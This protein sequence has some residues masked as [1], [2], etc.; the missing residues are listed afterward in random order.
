MDKPV[1]LLM[2]VGQEYTV[3]EYIAES[4]A[5]GVSKR[6]P[7]T[8][9]PNGI[10]PGVSRL[11]LWHTK[12][13][14]LVRAEACT[15]FD[16][17]SRLIDLGALTRDQATVYE[18]GEM[19]R[20]DDGLLLPDSYVPPHILMVTCAIQKLPPA[21]RRQLEKDFKIEWQGGIFSWTYLG[22]PQMVVP[23][24]ATEAD[25]PEEVRGRTDIDFV[26]VEYV[27][28]DGGDE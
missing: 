24:D 10:V 2:L 16:V 26:V 21:D 27:D 19:W 9:I 11:F 3:P 18:L 28:T 1:D 12:V 13:I 15:L 8:A 20:P 23:K 25:L 7:L 5:Y 22:L 14:P 4:V 17:V 6:I